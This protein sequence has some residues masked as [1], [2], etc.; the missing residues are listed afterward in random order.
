MVVEMEEKLFSGRFPRHTAGRGLLVVLLLVAAG[1]LVLEVLRPARSVGAEAVS[2]GQSGEVF[3]VAGKITEDTYGVYL[4]NR[5]TG[6]MTVYQWVPGK[7]GKL[8][9]A[10]ARNCTFDLQLDDYNTEPRPSEIKD[11]V[12]AARRL[13]SSQPQ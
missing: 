8:R 6:I 2:A 5:E 10:A 1:A 4:I 13:G 12:R 9:L 3:A 11:L 7:P